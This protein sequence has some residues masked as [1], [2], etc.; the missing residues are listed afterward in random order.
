[1]NIGRLASGDP[2]DELRG[3]LREREV[4]VWCLVA[5]VAE[6]GPTSRLLWYLP[7]VFTDSGQTVATGREVYGYPKQ[8]GT[9]DA[10]YP[11]QKKQLRPGDKLILCSDGVNHGDTNGNDALIEAAY[12]LGGSGPS[13]LR[14]IV[15]PHAAPGIVAGCIVVFMLALIFIR[16]FSSINQARR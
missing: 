7:Y 2:H 12:N 8:V 3:Y 5:D 10:D 13:I 9:F 14:R 1:M 6:T 4:S 15:I 16:V 11:A